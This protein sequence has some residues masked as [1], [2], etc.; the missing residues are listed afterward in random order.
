[1]LCCAVQVVLA[2]HRILTQEV[3]AAR[4][5]ASDERQ[6]RTVRVL[7]AEGERRIRTFA[8]HLRS[9]SRGRVNLTHISDRSPQL[10]RCERAVLDNADPTC[11]HLLQHVR[12]AA[13]QSG[14]NVNLP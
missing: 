4:R 5:R 8:V 13:V 11:R 6:G 7:Q 1:M 9:E 12:L 2:Y 14:I 3:D 10:E